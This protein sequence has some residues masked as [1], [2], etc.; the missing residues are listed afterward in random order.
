MFKLTLAGAGAWL[1]LPT[2]QPP[3][4]VIPVPQFTT[5]AGSSLVYLRHPNALHHYQ[6]LC[7]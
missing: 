6:H 4:V 2:T 1:E 5:S 3:T 7:R